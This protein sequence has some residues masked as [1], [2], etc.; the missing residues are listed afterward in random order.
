MKVRNFLAIA[1][2]SAVSLSSCSDKVVSDDYVSYVDPLIGSGGH[3]HV[4]VGASVPHGMVQLGPN[5]NATGW[6]WCSGYHD[7]DSTIIGFA[8]THLSGTGIADLGD[9]IFMPV[10]GVIAEGDSLPVNKYVSTFSKALEHVVPGY[11]SVEL[12]RTGIK[13]ELT[14]TDR[15]G[16]H[17]YCYPEG[18]NAQLVIDLDNAPKSIGGR[19]GVTG[20]SIGVIDS[21]TVSG[22]RNSDEWARDHKVYFHTKFSS[23]IKSYQIVRDGD[24]TKALID[25]G[26]LG[27]PLIVRTGISYTSREGAA[28]NLETEDGG[29]DFDEVRSE[30]YSRWNDA[31]STIDF[32]ASDETKRIFYTALYHTMI[33]PSLFADADGSYRGADGEIYKAEGF[34]PYTIFSLWDTYRA[35]HP[36]YTL[37]DG[38]ASDYVNSLIDIS[39]RQKALPVWHL[40]GN[41]TNCMVG[42]HSVPVIVDACLKNISG[43]DR[44]AAYREVSRIDRMQ[45]PGLEYMR[46]TGYI[47]ADKVPWSVAR[48]LEY[49]IDFYSTAQLAEALGRTGD[50]KRYMEQ[51]GNYRHYFDA[52]TG[53]MRGKL[54][55]GSRRTDFD[56]SYSLHMEDDY[57][58]GNA[59]QYTWLVPH[60]VEGLIELMGG[61]Q[62]FEQKLDSLFAVSSELNEGASADITGMIG[63]YAHGNEPGHHII[64][65][66][67]YI[68]RAD[69][70]S[71]R[72]REVYDKFYTTEADGLI[73]NEDCGQMSAWY[74]FSALGFYPVNPVDGTFVLGSPLADHATLKLANGKEF[75]VDV[76][77]NSA[78]NRYIGAVRLNGKPY[79]SH[80]LHYDDIMSGGVL[81]I[82]MTSAKR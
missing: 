12:D 80:L 50:Y 19:K 61:K 69:K 24:A 37:V 18:V 81:E 58:E 67:G 73:G 20:S 21:V 26:P 82:E 25:F 46:H 33:A 39:A 27:E 74:I 72:L 3:G 62:K 77:N 55:D 48:G 28:V 22:F 65:L 30:A 23:P 60:D 49:C 66:Y 76:R 14:A 16:Y 29:R 32:E 2:V 51:A 6:D 68:G 35:V 75:T 5:N 70:M 54:A 40:A 43:I 38:N 8:H 7:T 56:P 36:L 13:A 11:Y 42:L 78:D 44:E 1:F 9:V 71:D 31:L 10:T 47:P 41:E 53:F 34:T 17:R 59:W 4:F 15:V 45:S 57:V 63:Q 52:A 79:D 64:Y